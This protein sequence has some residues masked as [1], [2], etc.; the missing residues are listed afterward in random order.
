MWLCHD[1][2]M[3]APAPFVASSSTKR[4]TSVKFFTSSSWL[5][6]A[7]SIHLFFYNCLGIM[8]S[9]YFL[10]LPLST[11]QKGKKIYSDAFGNYAIPI[12]C[13]FKKTFH[14][15]FLMTCPLSKTPP[16]CG[17]GNQITHCDTITLVPLRTT[18]WLCEQQLCNLK[19]RC[20]YY[21]CE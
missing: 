13:S 17:A 20:V 16:E 15:Y 9:C 21:S 10:P 1:A 18:L 2:A 14:H 19:P 12:F 8:I 3:V 4:R 6:T 11:I 5:I 7:S